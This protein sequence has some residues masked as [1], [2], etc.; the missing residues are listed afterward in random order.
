[1]LRAVA[2][3]FLVIGW[4][5]AAGWPTWFAYQAGAATPVLWA[6]GTLTIAICVT[7]IYLLAGYISTGSDNQPGSGTGPALDSRVQATTRS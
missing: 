5:F 7:Q 3:P 2:V 6:A 4:Y 1:M